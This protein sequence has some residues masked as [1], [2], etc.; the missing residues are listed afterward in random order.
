[1][2]R[3]RVRGW[4]RS[5]APLH[6][7]G[8]GQGPVRLL[9]VATDGLGRPYVPGTG[10]AG[11]LRAIAGRAPG[12][13]EQR[14]RKLWGWAEPKSQ[15]GTVSRV[16]VRDA[17]LA[18]DT[19]VDAYGMPARPLDPA[20]LE[21]RFSVGIDRFTGTAAHGF[22]HGRIIVP[23]G[24]FL[25]L[26][27]DV[28]TAP[29][30]ATDDA[31]HLRYLL[32]VLRD[33]QVRLGAARTRGLGR[34]ELVTDHTE[35][36]E[37]D[38]TTPAGLVAALGHA[39]RPSPRWNLD[40]EL[41]G[42]P[43][44][45]LLTVRVDWEPAAPLMVRAAV[46]G[47]TVDAVPYTSATGPGEVALVLP[48]SALKGR[49]RAQAER[50]ERTVRGVDVVSSSDV[51]HDSSGPGAEA[52]RSAAF[53]AQLDELGAVRVLFGTARHAGVISVDD[54]FAATPMAEDDWQKVLLGVPGKDEDGAPGPDPGG[55]PPAAEDP[56]PALRAEYGLRRADHVAIDR[57]T[58][59]AAEGRLYSVLEPNATTW[60]P[61]A[62]TVDEAR[63]DAQG[64]LAAPARAL[65][66]LVLRD[67][68][69]GRIPLGWG[70]H[71]GMGDITVK[72]VTLTLPTG[73]TDV[74][75]REYLSGPEAA[76]LATQWCRYL[77]G[78]PT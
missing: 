18:E 58:G 44:P 27:L 48:G 5:L 31:T 15:E 59:G 21:T 71:R 4:L 9:A 70:T 1:M 50:I 54:C 22:L 55:A 26:E 34:V 11:A 66:L 17:L 42:G 75:L 35:V 46:D 40:E 24:T 56:L 20:R 23:R 57:F 7:G 19:T 13:D 32:R 39:T 45:G 12:I 10:L 41:R 16:V 77:D 36:H 14:L 6:V 76:E 61:L 65:L 68:E 38:L 60:Q 78:S 72:A 49:L 63:L 43:G 64:D 33:G 29:D 25:R 74:S 37:D 47:A 30:T 62:L 53:R 3:L 51:D 67:L 28:T 2:R 73:G 69:A 52:A 8:A